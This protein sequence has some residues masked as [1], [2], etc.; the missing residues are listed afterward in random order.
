MKAI[1]LTRSNLIGLANGG[2][3]AAQRLLKIPHA[4]KAKVSWKAIEC[5][6]FETTHFS[7]A[8][9]LFKHHSDSQLFRVLTLRKRRAYFESRLTKIQKLT[10]RRTLSQDPDSEVA[11]FDR[12]VSRYRRSLLYILVV[13]SFKHLYK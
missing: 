3:T 12:T 11:L 7:S 13:I 2:K 8:A 5:Y 10:V 9:K 4:A 6:L 1:Q